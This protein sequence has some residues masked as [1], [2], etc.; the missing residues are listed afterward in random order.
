MKKGMQY[1]PF[2]SV[3]GAALKAALKIRNDIKLNLIAKK[4]LRRRKLLTLQAIK[5]LNETIEAS[6]F[7]FDEFRRKFLNNILRVRVPGTVGHF[8]VQKFLVHKLQELGWHVELDQF[9]DDTPYGKR[10]FTNIMATLDPDADRQLALAAH[11]DSKL[12]TPDENGKHFIAA[13]DSAVPC[14]M[15]LDFAEVLAKKA[16][17]RRE[18]LKER[19]P[20]LIF[21]DGEEAFVNWSKNDSIYGSRH[22]A[23]VFAKKPHVTRSSIKVSDSIDAFVLL[24]LLG[25]AQPK[26]LNM[27]SKTAHLYNRLQLIEYYMHLAGQIDNKAPFFV[28]RGDFPV[29]IEDDHVPFMQEGIPILHII[30]VPFPD[31]WHKLSDDENVIDPSTVKNLVKVFRQFLLEYFRLY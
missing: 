13:T 12:M 16:K 6:D 30:P 11:Y 29:Q 1:D 9:I 27:F 21:L 20:L 10:K 22:L 17:T 25:A 2:G 18:A 24:D 14:A 28:G 8:E 23:Q 19:S 4:R 31:V 26:I 3:S 5:K 15:L 7:D